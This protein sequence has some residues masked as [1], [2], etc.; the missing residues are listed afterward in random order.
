MNKE[1]TICVAD[2]RRYAGPRGNFGPGSVLTVPESEAEALVSAGAA[3]RV[4]SLQKFEPQP[5][6][7]KPQGEIERRETAD[8]KPVRK[9]RTAKK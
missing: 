5:A 9:R 6:K 8:N 4:A 7:V 1:T 2:G 3:E